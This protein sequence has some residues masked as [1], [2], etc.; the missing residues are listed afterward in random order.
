MA[1]GVTATGFVRKRLPEIKAGLEAEL[2]ARFGEINTE[3]DS[4]FGQIIGVLS[5]ASADEWEAM[6][7]VYNA[8]YP[9]TATGTSLDNC[10]DLVGINRIEATRTRVTLDLTGTP[11]VTIPAGSQA[12]IPET[13]DVFATLA[14][15]PLT[16]SACVAARLAFNSTSAGTYTVSVNFDVA[17]L[18]YTTG[19][20]QTLLA[21]AINALDEPVTATVDGTQIVLTADDGETTFLLELSTQI[22][23]QTVT[24]PVESEAIQ[25]GPI[26]ALAGTIDNINT[27]V[28]GWADVANP[29][30]G[31]TGRNVETDV[32][33]R[34]RRRNSLRVI[35]SASVEAIRSR[36]IQE[37]QDVISV[38]I[39]ENRTPVTDEF[40]R[41]SHS[42]EA[43]VQGGDEDEIAARLWQLKPA[44]IQTHGNTTV[45]I[46]D[47]QGDAQAMKF[48]RPVEVPIA[49]EVDVQIDAT[50]FPALGAQSI[51]DA[52]VAFGNSLAV[53]EDVAPQRFFCDILA[54][55]GVLAVAMVVSVKAEPSTETS[56][57]L[58]IG[59]V[60]IATFDGDD[61]IVD[62]TTG[63]L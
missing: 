9:A 24:C 18:V 1:Y 41:P 7:A 47:S 36:L 31:V 29:F 44:G 43:V 62:L 49:V 14:A 17:T 25:T 12:T 37:I 54:F 33:L 38:A 40:G 20:L 61:V 8:F 10:A 34:L 32:E 58:A 51:R 42:F 39:F 59:Q 11:G 26:V 6:E 2:R 28:S 4:V 50:K 22:V 23:A 55:P 27:P 60:Q 16:A 30:A 56:G 5:K 15:G 63:S 35:G 13:G 3:P 19:S 46:T 52:I 21:A 45:L 53:G 57:V 48:S